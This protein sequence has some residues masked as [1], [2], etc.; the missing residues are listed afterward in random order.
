MVFP[1]PR[2]S[3]EAFALPS[4]AALSDQ[5]DFALV[6]L[7]FGSD[8]MWTWRTSRWC[9]R[10]WR[11]A[12]RMARSPLL[13]PRKLREAERQA[14]RAAV[15]SAM[16]RAKVQGAVEKIG[17]LVKPMRALASVAVRI[18]IPAAAQT[19]QFE[20]DRSGTVAQA[21]TKLLDGLAVCA[22]LHDGR[23]RKLPP[24][25]L[26][27]A[28]AGQPLEPEAVAEPETE[29]DKQP[30]VAEIMSKCNIANAAALAEI[31]TTLASQLRQLY[32]DD[33][34]RTEGMSLAHEIH[35]VWS[36]ERL[37]AVVKQLE[38]SMQH[39][40]GGENLVACRM[41]CSNNDRF[42]VQEL[43]AALAH[44]DP[45]MALAQLMLR[46][47]RQSATIQLQVVKPKDLLSTGA[48][49]EA[50][51]QELELDRKAAALLAQQTGEYVIE[52]STSTELAPADRDLDSGNAAKERW[53]RGVEKLRRSRSEAVL[54]L[55]VA[56][57][58]D[59]WR[60][61]A[62]ELFARCV[63]C[64]AVFSSNFFLTWSAV[65]NKHASRYD[66][67]KTGYLTKDQ[68]KRYLHG[69]G[70]FG[71]ND[72]CGPDSWDRAFVC[73]VFQI[74]SVIETCRA[75]RFYELTVWVV[76]ARVFT[77]SII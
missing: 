51:L 65:F 33:A 8:T 55:P 48:Q 76:R 73:A 66:D 74:G 21:K 47:M 13:D 11:R 67:D 72:R 39:R 49:H 57:L 24:D 5:T 40:L 1:P 18:E 70:V 7:H 45:P 42:S 31:E 54:Q 61:L 53:K 22:V 35:E 4:R 50:T 27:F 34:L 2:Y 58:G 43:R 38:T 20:W 68:Y 26:Q 75:C 19:V 3:M 32:T 71:H 64:F 46:G 9:L 23:R 37:H 16:G 63:G 77:C 29:P 62:E 6:A 17:R 10:R 30:T 59:Q 12:T 69:V 60:L 15:R 56:E 25:E 36:P 41:K 14:E 44:A 28:F 52:L